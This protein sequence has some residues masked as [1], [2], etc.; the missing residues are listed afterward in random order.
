MV[1]ID[2]GQ[3]Q[4]FFSG[5]SNTIRYKNEQGKFKN[6]KFYGVMGVINQF[7]DMGYKFVNAYA[8]T[9]NKSHVYHYIMEKRTK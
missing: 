5:S 7:Y 1:T 4:K 2:Y 9:I 6:A 8:I 3:K